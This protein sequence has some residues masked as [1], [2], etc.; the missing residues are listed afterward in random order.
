[1]P[2]GNNPP[3][4]T[5]L[6]DQAGEEYKRLEVELRKLREERDELIDRLEKRFKPMVRT[7]AGV[8]AAV[9]F[10]LAGAWGV[11][12]IIGY[13]QTLENSV[14][15]QVDDKV[16]RQFPDAV[17]EALKDVKIQNAVSELKLSNIESRIG[18]DEKML[19]DAHPKIIF[20]N[21]SYDT[22]KG[23]VADWETH[24]TAAKGEVET[25][26]SQ[27]LQKI[28]ND[29]N[30]LKETTTKWIRQLY[31]GLAEVQTYKST[32]P[33]PD[34]ISSGRDGVDPNNI[35]AL[36]K[37]FAARETID[38]D[39]A[40]HVAQWDNSEAPIKG[41]IWLEVGNENITPQDDRLAWP[42]GNEAP[43]PWSAFTKP[44]TE[45]VTKKAVLLRAAPP[46]SVEDVPK[47]LA[48]LP[49]HTRIKTVTDP[50]PYKAMCNRWSQTCPN[51]AECWMEVEVLPY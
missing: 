30:A 14:G 4:S 37:Y 31:I 24:L 48:L 2:N 23:E 40:R 39:L 28:N 32:V 5:P 21:N 33:R 13:R 42:G 16:N 51:G 12:N 35:V 17:R 9:A 26:K 34:A 6:A 19:A 46:A 38:D 20:I 47:T 29:A 44:G 45:F 50:T 49:N 7:W 22:L 41:W 10:A 36:R 27:A 3:S 18:S 1:M 8:G 11:F 15:K 25:Q 43:V